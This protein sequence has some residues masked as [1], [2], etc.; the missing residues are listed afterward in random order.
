MNINDETVQVVSVNVKEGDFVKG[1]DIIGA[2]E[3]DKS[4]VDVIAERDGYVLKVLCRPDQ[5]V[6]VGSVMLWMGETVDEPVPQDEAVQTR[7]VGESG[8]PTAKA[9]AMLTQLGLDSARIPASGKR[10]TAADIEA[11]LAR[12]GQGR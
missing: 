8:R 1:G 6:A 11:W 9:R 10:L 12:T 3:T 2:V 7:S 4:L 5:K